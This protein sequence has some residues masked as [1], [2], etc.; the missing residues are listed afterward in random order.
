[1]TALGRAHCVRQGHV[2]GNKSDR[3]AGA[4]AAGLAELTGAATVSG[5]Q[6]QHGAPSAQCAADVFEG[7][8]TARGS[9]SRRVRTKRGHGADGPGMLAHPTKVQMARHHHRDSFPEKFFSAVSTY[10]QQ[11]PQ[12]AYWEQGSNP[13]ALT[14]QSFQHFYQHGPMGRV[15]ESQKGEQGCRKALFVALRLWKF[16]V[17]SFPPG[18]VH[19]SHPGI[20]VSHPLA[21]AFGPAG[22]DHPALLA[23]KHGKSQQKPCETSRSRTVSPIA[24]LS[25]R[26]LPVVDDDV[27]LT[28]ADQRE[29]DKLTLELM[30]GDA[31]V[32]PGMPFGGVAYPANP[33]DQHRPGSPS[34]TFTVPDVLSIFGLRPEDLLLDSNLGADH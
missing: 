18:M 19:K 32:Q 25:Q 4:G 3:D 33:P 28:E 6:G 24:S 1:M 16:D 21:N 12:Q 15:C 29:I 14:I 13:P 31:N 34:G 7:D 26:A 30:A 5:S 2:E 23:N 10:M 20:T 27:A 17:T 22:C 8:I 11:F 9:C